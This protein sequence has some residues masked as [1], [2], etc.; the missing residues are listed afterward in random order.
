MARTPTASVPR[1]TNVA[2]DTEGSG[3]HPRFAEALTALGLGELHPGSAG[4]RRPPGPRPRP[5]PPSAAS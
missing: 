1:M 2:Q 3:A 4:S 5:P